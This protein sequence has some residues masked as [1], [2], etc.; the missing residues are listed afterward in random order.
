MMRGSPCGTG[1]GIADGFVALLFAAG[2][3][4]WILGRAR[5]RPA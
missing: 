1:V 2:A 4:T 3:A 5:P